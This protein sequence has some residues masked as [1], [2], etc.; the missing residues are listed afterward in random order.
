MEGRRE[1][2]EAS[3]GGSDGRVYASAT[4]TGWERLRELSSVRP[5]MGRSQCGQPSRSSAL[6]FSVKTW[7]YATV[8]TR[9]SSLNSFSPD[10]E[11]L[12]FC[13]FALL[14][15]VGS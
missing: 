14:A 1:G 11:T 15:A 10:D 2:G 6:T 8:R 7:R 3:F 12:G 9:I 4:A 5:E 13:R